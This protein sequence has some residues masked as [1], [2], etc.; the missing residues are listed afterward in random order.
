MLIPPVVTLPSDPEDATA[1]FAAAEPKKTVVDED[2]ERVLRESSRQ[3]FDL[4]A[5]MAKVQKDPVY[6]DE[7]VASLT[8]LVTDMQR[9]LRAGLLG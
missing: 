4:R 6:H 7:L 1:P 9:H 3:Q 2:V 5:E 8:A